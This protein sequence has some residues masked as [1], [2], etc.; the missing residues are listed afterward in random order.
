MIFNKK[1]I[2]PFLLFLCIPSFGQV[3]ESCDNP[4][5]V[6]NGFETQVSIGDTWFYDV[7]TDLPLTGYFYPDQFSIP[8]DYIDSAQIATCFPIVTIDLGCNGNYSTLAQQLI[9]IAQFGGYT[10]PL[11]ETWKPILKRTKKY[12]LESD[13]TLEQLHSLTKDSV[14]FYREIGE[15]FVEAFAM[16]GVTEDVPAYVKVSFPTSGKIAFK[17][18]SVMTRCGDQSVKVEKENKYAIEANDERFFYYLPND[19]RTDYEGLKF[20]WEGRSQAD[21]YMYKDCE[22]NNIDYDFVEQNF[23]SSP[24]VDRESNL[25]FTIEPNQVVLALESEELNNYCR[26][27]SSYIFFQVKADSYGM[28]FLGD[29][30]D[31]TVGVEAEQLTRKQLH[32]VVHNRT[33]NITST[34]TQ[35]IA[36][37]TTTGCILKSTQIRENE[38]ISVELPQGVYI[39]KSTNETK[40]III[41]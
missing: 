10:I 38:T 41:N 19:L 8:E 28:L 37:Y 1:H 32:I 34:T 31:N 15:Q 23:V 9:Y 4:F 3:G 17:S 11:K 30:S 36:I 29:Q 6:S 18:T 24:K 26:Y 21:I 33:A 25:W 40:K 5:V 7:S 16:L 22:R 2:V 13:L 12:I 39:L 20:Y 14:F 27:S 35:F